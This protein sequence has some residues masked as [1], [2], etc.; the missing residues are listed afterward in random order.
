[1]PPKNT[2][3][4]SFDWPYVLRTSRGGACRGHYERAAVELKGYRRAPQ[5]P[6]RP[7]Q[8]LFLAMTKWQLGSCD[9]PVDCLR[10][11][12]AID[13]RPLWHSFN[14]RLP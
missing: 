5:Q 8:Q 12:P 2:A 3:H 4:N 9:E 14:N 11:Q 10:N 1:M 7:I 13:E 6:E